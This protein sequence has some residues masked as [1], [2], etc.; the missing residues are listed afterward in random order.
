MSIIGTVIF[1]AVAGGLGKLALPGKDPGGFIVTIVLGVAGA[2]LMN[3]LANLVGFSTEG[4]VIKELIAAI[5][6]VV[7]L[8]LGYRQFLKMRGNGPTA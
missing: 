3:F 1:G 6:G 5:I 2:V 7:L 8:L 4:S